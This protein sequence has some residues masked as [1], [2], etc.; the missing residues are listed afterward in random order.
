MVIEVDGVALHADVEG[1][2]DAPVVVFLHGVSGSSGTYGWLP[3]EVTDGRRVVRLDLR[4]HGR[5]A[6]AP[7]S[8]VIERYGADVAAVLERVAGRPAVLVGHSLGGVAAWWV[9]QRRPELVAAAFLEDP[10]LYMGEPA[11]HERNEI[12]RL[13]PLMRDRAAAWQ[14]EGVDVATAA[15]QIGDA[16]FTPD[17]SVRMRDA[18][19]EDALRSRAEAQLAMDPEVLTG[20][21][22]RST[23]AATDTSSPVGVP[24]MILAADDA[25]NAAFPSRHERRLAETHPE[26]EVVRLA[27]ASHGIHDEL[28]HRDAY[29]EHLAAFLARYA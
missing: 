10:P 5:S 23:L 9:A 21:A 4:G 14:R 17:G 2:E 16:P 7:G 27:G 15:E 13:F 12:A 26:V 6:H 28:R 18:V 19:H 24:V 25:M 22:D 20:A 8:Y 29:V 3:A 1:L 11:E